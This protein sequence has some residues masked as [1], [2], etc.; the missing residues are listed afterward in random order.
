MRESLARAGAAVI[1]LAALAGCAGIP[2]TG[3]VVEGRALT[4]TDSGDFDFFPL[5]PAVGADQEDILRGFVAAFTGSAGDYARAREFLSSDFADEWSPRA[6]VTVRGALERYSQVAPD[7]IEYIVDA[8]ATVDASGAYQ[9]NDTP[10]QRT[11]LYQFV[12]EGGEWR[13]SLAPDG[14]VLS[15]GLFRSVFDQQVLYFLDPTSQHLVPDLRYFLGGTAAL[16]I[17]SSLLAGPPPWLQGAVRT[18]FPDGTQLSSPT[19]DVESG[20]ATVDLSADALVASQTDRRLMQQQLD[21]S[22]VTVTTIR[23]V[24]ITV[25]GSPLAVQEGEATLVAEPAVDSRPIVFAD[26]E[27]GYLGASSISTFGQ[28]SSRVVDTAPTAATVS[29]TQSA[30]AVLSPAGVS[31]VRTGDAGVVL[32]DDRPSLLP[33][34]L[35]EYDFVWSATSAP[36]S[37]TVFG[38]DGSPS[39]L[40]TGFPSD[41][42]V[43]SFEVSRDGARVAFLLDA[44]GGPRLVV[45][46]IVRDANRGQVPVSLGTP[47]VDTTVRGGSTAIDATWV[48]N[49]RVATLSTSGEVATATLFEVGGEISDLGRPGPA[50]AVVGGNGPTDLRAL[51]A[52]GTILGRS[53]NGWAD[54]NERVTF[55]ATQR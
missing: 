13:I 18:A 29:D 48:D 28:L 53:G 46:A 36:E 25:A 40:P 41:S 8:D 51:G 43:R 26:G 35:D 42:L 6:G 15:D 45:R 54:Q 52:D 17:V 11:L 19:I 10:V 50:L 33:P 7:T 2:T 27:F 31:I 49:T 30:A 12:Q 47:V 39:S 20:T 22:L 5:A 21:A 38:A 32:L 4:E 23:R 3:G 24:A 9:R 37:V 44:V 55:L 16:R 14:I 34:S 1:L